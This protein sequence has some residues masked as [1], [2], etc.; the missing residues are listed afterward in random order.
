MKTIII[1][2]S[3][4]LD[5]FCSGAIAK[6]KF[7]DGELVGY[8]YNKPFDFGMIPLDDCQVFMIDVSMSMTDMKKISDLT[9]GRFTWID[10]HISAINDYNEKTAADG[11]VPCIAFTNIKKAACELAWEYF[12][13]EEEM[14]EGIHLLGEYDTWRNED[15]ARWE[16]EI[17]PFQ[18]GCRLAF[19]GPMD[20]CKAFLGLSDPDYIEAV[21]SIGD[22]ILAYQTQQNR[23]A[24]GSAFE[25]VFEGLPAVCCNIGGANSIAFDSVYDPSR[26]KLMIPFKFDGSEWRASLYTTHDDVD[27]SEIA[28][29]YGGGGHRKA[30]GFRVV[31]IVCPFQGTRVERKPNPHDR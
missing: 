17:L 6:M 30:S 10:H 22:N 16:E 9:H 24:C 25:M 29:K 1:Y 18:Y 13:P 8:D 27:C 7:P 26:H 4:D 23:I 15:L 5:G 31:S 20:I 14:P 19:Y 2:H 12:F 28:K 3:A 21:K 11:E